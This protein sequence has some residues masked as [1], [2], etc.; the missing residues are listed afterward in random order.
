MSPVVHGTRSEVRVEN[1]DDGRRRVSKDGIVNDV[2]E[3]NQ[4]N[5]E[6]REMVC[7]RM[8]TKAEGCIRIRNA[9]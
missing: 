3:I 7:Q 9:Y 4:L 5:R 1:G 2:Q 6:N 8:E